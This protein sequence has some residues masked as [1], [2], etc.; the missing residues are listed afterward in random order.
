MPIVVP[1]SWI[2]NF[3]RP[4]S[5]LALTYVQQGKYEQAIDLYRQS[6]ELLLENREKALSWNRLGERVPP[7]EGLQAGGGGLPQRG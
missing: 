5:N 1:S 4:Y 7:P 6:I 2:E 3:G